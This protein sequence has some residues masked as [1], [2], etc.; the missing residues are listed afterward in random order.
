[1]KTLL[2]S[3][4]SNVTHEMRET[5]ERCPHC[6]APLREGILNFF[7]QKKI[8][9]ITCPCVVAKKEVE[10]QAR[11]AAEYRERLAKLR[12][13]SGVPPKY[14]TATFDNF[15]PRK[16]AER[17]LTACRNYAE[18]FPDLKSRG[19]GMYLYGTSGSG[20]SRLAASIANRLLDAGVPVKWWNITSLYLAIQGTFRP[21]Y[22]GP[23]ILEGCSRTSLLILDDMG[24]E[25]PSEWTMA[26][27]YDIVNTRIENLLPTIITSNFMLEELEA[28]ADS[29]VI[30]RLSDRDVF[31][32]VANTATDYRK[33]KNG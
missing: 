2:N 3:M 23:D 5:G 11:K 13:R 21:D 17:V 27:M 12:E 26:T 20:K 4:E 7:G 29:R 9:N 24:A 16:G 1:M 10:E 19:I 18:K 25:K 31:P 28:K 6:G 22:N 30:S 33:K 32:R 15:K 8:F 14:A